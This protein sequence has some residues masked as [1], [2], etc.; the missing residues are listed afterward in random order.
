M[1]T[2]VLL[3]LGLALVTLALLAA[4]PANASTAPVLACGSTVLTQC[5]DTAHFDQLD[6]WGTP[7]GA[8][9]NCPSYVAN[10]YAYMVGSGNG[11]EHNTINKAGDFWGT[12]T[13]TGNV[14]FTFYDPGNVEVAMDDQGN[15]ISATITGPPDNVVTAR[16]T[17][18]FGVQ[19]N[20]QNGNIG[21]TFS[22]AGADQDGAPIQIHGNW[23]VNWTPGTE[24][25]SGPPHHA[26]YTVSC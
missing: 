10:D 19:D 25:F 6:Q 26:K 12:M 13:F 9:D 16:F 20:R 11:V 1:R 17:Q 4:A 15:V 18:W 3:A 21:Q 23:H 22:V 5:T 8:G 24:A 2:R 14:S 7:L